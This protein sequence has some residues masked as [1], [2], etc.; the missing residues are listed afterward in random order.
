M[1]VSERFCEDCNVISIH[2]TSFCCCFVSLEGEGATSD[3]VCSF[4]V[5]K[6][7]VFLYVSWQLK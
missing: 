1:V 6:V 7:N 4:S 5:G 3:L 2:F